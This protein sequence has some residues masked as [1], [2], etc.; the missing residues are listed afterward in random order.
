MRAIDPRLLRRTRA[1]RPLLALDTA[2]GIGS[3]A[4]VLVQ[5]S[6]LALIVARAF[7]G[8]PLAKL[9]PWFALLVTAFVLRGAFAWAM[10]VAGRRA[11]WSVLSELRIALVEK[12]LR[13][14][15]LGGR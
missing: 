12:R 6:V 10:E 5:A 15:P 1:A 4:A 14:Q 8:E 3:A 2:L 11:A 7:R 9:L 13:T